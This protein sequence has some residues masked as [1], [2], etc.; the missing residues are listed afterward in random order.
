[1]I[2]YFSLFQNKKQLFSIVLKI[3]NRIIFYKNISHDL[4]IYEINRKTKIETKEFV[5]T[6]V[7]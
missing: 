3:D 7:R 2:S 4:L 5:K 1:M 6:F